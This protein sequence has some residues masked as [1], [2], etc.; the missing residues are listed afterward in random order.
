MIGI[1]CIENNERT[2]SV[3][4]FMD[5]DFYSEL[6]AMVVLLGPKE[7]I[8][9]ASDA[10]VNMFMVNKS[11]FFTNIYMFLQYSMNELRPL[12]RETT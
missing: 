6:E 11:N 8:L 5:N 7:C 4:E 10:E 2:F 12:W 9:P 1:A 3:S